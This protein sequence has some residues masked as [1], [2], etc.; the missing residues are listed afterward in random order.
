MNDSMSV[1][2]TDTF[3]AEYPYLLQGYAT[4]NAGNQVTGYTRIESQFQSAT[5][6]NTAPELTDN[7][8]D[9]ALMQFVDSTSTCN[10]T[11]HR[12]HPLV[13]DSGV[14][15]DYNLS[16]RNVGQYSFSIRD[17]G[18]TKV[19]Q[20]ENNPYKTLFDASC[21]G[22]SL[23]GCNDCG[24]G[25]GSNTLNTDNKFGCSTR[26]DLS[27]GTY[28][29]LN[30]AFKPYQ[31]DLNSI[32]FHT[33]PNEANGY[34][35]MNDL[36]NNSQMAVKL[37]GNITAEGYNGN[38]LSNFTSTCAA[39]N[40]NLWIDR[41]MLPNETSITTEG[42]ATPVY[43]QQG[44]KDNTATL[45]IIDNSSGTDMNSTLTAS[46]FYSSIDRN[47]T[48]TVDLYFNFTKPYND[49]VNPIDVNITMLHAGSPIASSNA[50]SLT[51]YVPDGNQ[52][53]I[54]GDRYFYFGRVT[55]AGADGQQIYDP[56]YSTSLSVQVYC[57]TSTTPAGMNC[58]L[59]P[60]LLAETGNW[61]R[62]ATHTSA[63]N[64]GQI[65]SLSTTVSG[66]TLNGVSPL[67]NLT[68]DSNGSTAGVTIAYPL[69]GRPVHPVIVIDTDEW[70]KYSTTRADG[71]PTFTLH[72]LTQG[73]RWK[74]KG[75][76][77]NVIQ[78]EPSNKST[79]RLNW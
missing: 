37:E 31:F 78:T 5:L 25:S 41:N 51:N 74:G 19:D 40:V 67:N 3:A 64:D 22:S 12:M 70:L 44:L 47:G 48:A 58:G 55:D 16:G 9:I 1:S 50:N 79:Q 10:D 60:G 39:S 28:E 20:A 13:F 42:V 53:I 46:N 36:N 61:Y 66:V 77:G 59:L 23:P 35:Y 32:T 17:N 4:N 29:A 26:S 15:R 54:G 38:A 75:N 34:L 7:T 2:H 18:W 24:I 33:S 69:A 72:F 63:S 27:D 21:S 45:S 65:N 68:F 73:L 11:T 8:I 43:F 76:T 62:M 49:T 71:K 14:L 52:T 30:L 6:S 57:D 56:S